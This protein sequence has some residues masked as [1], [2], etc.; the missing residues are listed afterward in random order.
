MFYWR[1]WLGIRVPA[2]RIVYVFCCFLVCNTLWLAFWLSCLCVWMRLYLCVC[3]VDAVH[4][5]VCLWCFVCMFV[6]RGY[7]DCLKGVSF[8]F[9]GLG[10]RYYGIGRVGLDLGLPWMCLGFWVWCP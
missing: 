10:F 2:F 7:F 8:R 6:G 1:L 4:V 9:W 3:W 5:C